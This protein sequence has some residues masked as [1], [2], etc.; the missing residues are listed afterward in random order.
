VFWWFER[1]REHIRFEV[2]DLG[3]SFELRVNYP[4]GA[5]QVERFGDSS[6]LARRQQQLQTEFAAQGWA[7]PHGPF[8]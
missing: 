7:G 6:D 1:G 2:L 5:E 8:F 4:D 3:G